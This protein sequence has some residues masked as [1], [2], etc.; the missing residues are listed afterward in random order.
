MDGFDG[1]VEQP[2]AVELAED[3]EYAARA[4]DVLD[5]DFLGGRGDFAYARGLPRKRFDVRH[6]KVNFGLPRYRQ[7]VEDGVC[8][9]A[10]SYIEAHCV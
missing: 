4:V 7:K 9:P 3:S 10:H 5:V 2:R 6:G 1:G 8:A